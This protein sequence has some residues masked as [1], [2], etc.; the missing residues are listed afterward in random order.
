M[1]ICRAR[2]VAFYIWRSIWTDFAVTILMEMCVNEL[3]PNW[4]NWTGA[5]LNWW[6]GLELRRYCQFV[7]MNECKKPESQFI[8]FMS[9]KFLRSNVQKSRTTAGKLI[10]NHYK[11]HISDKFINLTDTWRMWSKRYGENNHCCDIRLIFSETFQHQNPIKIY[12]QISF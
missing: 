6:N 3:L 1:H 10:R 11:K 5:E 2:C 8:Y 7:S 4:K 9:L 12:D